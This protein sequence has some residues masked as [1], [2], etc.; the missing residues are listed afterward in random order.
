[1]LRQLTR[2]LAALLVGVVATS[3]A[4][5]SAAA[6]SIDD[7]SAPGVRTA[8]VISLLNANPT[9][10]VTADGSVLGGERELEIAVSGTPSLVSAS[11]T[12]GEGSLASGSTGAAAVVTTLVYDG[13]GAAG[14]GAADLAAS[15]NKL[16]FDFLFADGAA[17]PGISIDVVMSNGAGSASFSG[18]VPDSDIPSVYTIPFASFTPVGGF[19]F[20]AVDLIAV[21]FNSALVKNVDF[22]LSSIHVVPEPST[23]AL[24]GLGLVGL[25]IARRRAR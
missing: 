3:G 9:T 8:W 12:V 15:G 25:L 19:S 11:G 18:V 23:L 13:V 22:E 4:T 6:L 20:S 2:A 1:M 5:A 7:F 24:A 14:L 21:R 17:A 16:V 10:V